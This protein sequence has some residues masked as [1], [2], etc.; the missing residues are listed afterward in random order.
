MS[1]YEN[2]EKIG[3]TIG[4]LCKAEIRIGEIK[5]E[6]FEATMSLVRPVEVLIRENLIPIQNIKVI[7]G[8]AVPPLLTKK[9]V[10]LHRFRIFDYLPETLAK[11]L[12]ENYSQNSVVSLILLLL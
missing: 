6:D 7:K 8:Q 1:V 9:N 2:G 12:S 3:L 11:N 5:K 4:D 10:D